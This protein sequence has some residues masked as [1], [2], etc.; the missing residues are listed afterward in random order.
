MHDGNDGD[1]DIFEDDDEHDD[2]YSRVVG[3][4]RLRLQDSLQLYDNF[5]TLRR[6]S[7][8]HGTLDKL[9]L[10]TVAGGGPFAGEDRDLAREFLLHETCPF[11]SEV[12]VRIVC[13]ACNEILA[14]GNMSNFV[15]TFC[16]PS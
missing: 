6:L 11:V 13:T 4:T 5:E 16:D 15:A 14:F 9:L 7:R 10:G 1:A 8:G 2:A 3:G 12:E